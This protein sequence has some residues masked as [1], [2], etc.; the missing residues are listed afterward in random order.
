MSE[1]LRLI[2]ESN[3]AIHQC[4]GAE[5]SP[6]MRVLREIADSLK[7]Q[8]MPVKKWRP[9]ISAHDLSPDTPNTAPNIARAG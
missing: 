2:A 7:P 8:T 9:Y 3:D 4:L 1:M 6:L 5:D